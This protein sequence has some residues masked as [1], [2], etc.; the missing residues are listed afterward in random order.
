MSDN[1]AESVNV[2]CFCCGKMA[3]PRKLV[4][5]EIKGKKQV[6]CTEDCYEFYIDYKGI[7]GM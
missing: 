5:K 1:V 3:M 7:K 4:M 6:F 2:R